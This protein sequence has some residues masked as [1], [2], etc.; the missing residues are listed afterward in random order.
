MR[1]RRGPLFWGLFLIPLGAVPLLV[2]A[3]AVD[4]ALFDEAWRLWP[5]VLVGFGLALIVGRGRASIVVTVVLA[6]ALGLAGGGAL[7]STNDWVGS[8]SNCTSNQASAS[9]STDGGTFATS[10]SVQLNLDCGDAHV[11]TGSGTAWALEAAYRGTPPTI[12]KS[13]SSLA[14][15]SPHGSGRHTWTLTLP[16]AATREM[17]VSANA[18]SA[19]VALA[20]SSLDRFEASVNA[21]DLRVDATGGSIAH[22]DVSMNAGRA[23]VT[24]AGG[25]TSGS[26]STNAGAID[27][28]VPSTAGLTLH[29]P[30]QFTF[31][32]NLAQRGLARDG[33]TWTRSGAAGSSI[34]LTING[35]VG[36]FTLDP[37]G[38]C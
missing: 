25:S 23:R 29:L 3:G 11:S 38:G 24:L 4:S 2:R 28:C 19:T 1:I 10:A 8:V 12:S 35:T 32:N 16:A 37:A 5:L 22:L 17:S 15:A 26:L 31:S 6:L 33:D 18:A 30:N 27:V 34:E 7:A 36:S 13:P 20:G 14:I 21:G 9:R